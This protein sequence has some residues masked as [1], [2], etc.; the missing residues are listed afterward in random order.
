MRIKRGDKTFRTH[1]T[2]LGTAKQDK[3][4]NFNVNESES[5][6]FGWMNMLGMKEKN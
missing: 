1:H 5:N 6:E 4:T 3:G 2:R